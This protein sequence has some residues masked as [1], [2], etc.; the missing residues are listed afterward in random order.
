MHLASA[1]KYIELK[2]SLSAGRYHLLKTSSEEICL[3]ANERDKK[4][5][6]N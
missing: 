2:Q 6:L 5:H 1:E 4:L 3:K